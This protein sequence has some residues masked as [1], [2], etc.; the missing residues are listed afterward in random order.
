MAQ[1]DTKAQ[2]RLFVARGRKHGITPQ[3]LLSFLREH[4]GVKEKLVSN[5]EIKDDFTFISV[6]HAEA[7]VIEKRFRQK[8][9][10]P[11]ISIARPEQ[12]RRMAG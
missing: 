5:I 1:P 6:P 7:D 12:S 9:G 10:R 8:R 11:L 3:N 2:T 4:T